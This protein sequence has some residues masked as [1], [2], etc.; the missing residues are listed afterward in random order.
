MMESRFKDT[1]RPG[2]GCS[3]DQPFEVVGEEIP[4]ARTAEIRIGRVT[5]CRETTINSPFFWLLGGVAVG[6]IGTY[7]IMREVRR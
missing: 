2:M 1:P 3:A 6:A 5:M 7:L 4:P